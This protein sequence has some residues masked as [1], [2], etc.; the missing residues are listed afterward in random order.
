MFSRQQDFFGILKVYSEKLAFRLAAIAIAL[1]AWAN[2]LFHVNIDAHASTINNVSPVIAI[3]GVGDQIE[4]KVEKDIGTVQ[5]KVGEVTGQTEGALKQ[6]KGE[7]KQGIGT[8]KNKLDNAQ[9]KVE[10]KSESFI[11]SVKEIFD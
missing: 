3:E 11:D 1:L 5:R 2:L 7:V 10:D 6:A 4:G 8:T 9:D